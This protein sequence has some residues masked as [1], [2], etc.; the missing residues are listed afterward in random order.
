MNYYII[1][2]VHGHADK[3]EGLL[4]KLQYSMK[5]GSLL[6]S[7]AKGCFSRGSDRQGAA[8]RQGH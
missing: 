4:A 1:G 5:K 8:E 6:P 2:D 3:L 7:G